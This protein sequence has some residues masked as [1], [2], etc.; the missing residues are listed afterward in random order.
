MTLSLKS[1]ALALAMAFA[2]LAYAPGAF[3]QEG[4]GQASAQPGDAA[5]RERAARDLIVEALPASRAPEIYGDL[6]RTLR[7]VYLPVMRDMVDG[8]VPGA[9]ADPLTADTM[10]KLVAFLTYAL[11]ASDDMDGTLN[12]SRDAMIS[13]AALTLAKHSSQ[14]E[15]NATRELLRM[16]AARKGGD[17][18]YAVSRLLTGFTYEE[19][20]SS[21]EFSDWA[22]ELATNIVAGKVKPDNSLPSPE[23]VAK[24]QAVVADLVRISRIDDMAADIFRFLR[25]VVLV[26]APPTDEERTKFRAQ[27]DQYEYNYN[28]QKAVLLAMA[29][30]M[31]AS[32]LS[33]KDLDK[34]H[35]YVRS[36][37]VAKTFVLFQDVVR[38]GTSFTAE[39]VQSLVSFAQEQEKKRTMQP[40]SPEEQA[41]ISAE[42]NVLADKWSATLTAGVS[43]EA[44]EGLTKL[45]AEFWAMYWA[46]AN[47]Q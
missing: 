28:M 39:D 22:Q 26:A 42:W 7:D 21:Y 12:A 18:I 5:E 23:K 38:A 24:A 11:R 1:L 46:A 31:L 25:G 33:D 41:A 4:G 13:D 14:D 16:P 34:L 19:T 10:R 37:A 43:P 27:L 2:A 29:P 15:I 6:R 20:R 40:R 32:S 44:R 17:T 35:D 47:P 8:K 45:A 3:A 9:E 36:P 30:S